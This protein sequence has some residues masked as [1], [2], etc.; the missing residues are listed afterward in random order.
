LLEL[1]IAVNPT[2]GCVVT[3]VDPEAV[4]GLLAALDDYRQRALYYRRLRQKYERA[5]RYPWIPV[6][7]DPPEPK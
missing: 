2:Q 1:S 5:A 7:S 4:Q 6:E 3:A